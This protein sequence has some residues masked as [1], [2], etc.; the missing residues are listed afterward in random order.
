M[1]TLQVHPEELNVT[2]SVEKILS[3]MN[4]RSK[5][6]RNERKQA[7]VCFS[8]LYFFIWTEQRSS[9]KESH[10]ESVKHRKHLLKIDKNGRLRPSIEGNVALI[11]STN[12]TSKGGWNWNNEPPEFGSGRFSR[13]TKCITVVLP[14]GSE[15]ALKVTLPC[16]N[17]PWYISFNNDDDPTLSSSHSTNTK[18]H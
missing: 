6:K 4:E 18:L 17:R 10:L 11:V 12:Q 3:L 7:P 13:V 16:R 8:S 14:A 15:S 1:G 5:L 9:R 2:L